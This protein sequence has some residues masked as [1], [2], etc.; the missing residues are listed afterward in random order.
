[1]KTNTI[2]FMRLCETHNLDVI[3]SYSYKGGG[4]ENC[5]TIHKNY[6]VLTS[7]SVKD[8]ESM[9]EEELE[10]IV[11]SASMSSLWS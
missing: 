5:W 3:E 11:Y 8:I 6:K 4:R 10:N 7:V 1:M 9:T 2:R